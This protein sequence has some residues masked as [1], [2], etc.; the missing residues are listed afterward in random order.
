MQDVSSEDRVGQILRAE[1]N[2][3]VGFTVIVNSALDKKKS[4]SS[5]L[6]KPETVAHPGKIAARPEIWEQTKEMLA[7]FGCRG[8]G[9][10]QRWRTRVGGPTS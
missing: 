9:R 2:R 3:Q 1:L 7:R 10:E 8:R 4:T 6:I 5:S